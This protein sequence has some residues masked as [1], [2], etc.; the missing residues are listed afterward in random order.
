MNSRGKNSVKFSYWQLI[1]HR[2]YHHLHH[3]S[4]L[5]LWFD[6]YYRT[7]SSGISE[8]LRT[9]NCT[10][11]V[12]PKSLQR[13]QTC[14]AIISVSNKREAGSASWENLRNLQIFKNSFNGCTKTE[15]EERINH[16][17]LVR[18]W[19][20]RSCNFHV[21]FLPHTSDISQTDFEQRGRASISVT[22]TS[23]NLCKF[24]NH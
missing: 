11:E 16:F 9:W 1:Q 8:L 13:I 3:R 15:V 17:I 24:P 10:S 6:E 22:V 2:S 21:Q 23:L 12:F 7:C 20:W 5:S 18:F 4:Y 19:H 14:R